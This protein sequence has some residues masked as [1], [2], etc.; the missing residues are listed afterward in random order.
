MTSQSEKTVK[1]NKD[2]GILRLCCKETTT[3]WKIYSEKKY[4]NKI[5][6]A[7]FINLSSC[8]HWTWMSQ[9]E[10]LFSI[11]ILMCQR[12]AVKGFKVWEPLADNTAT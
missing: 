8:F 12:Q 4:K 7:Q 2:N 5:S 6:Q 1:Q 9:Y 10:E 3:T 11:F